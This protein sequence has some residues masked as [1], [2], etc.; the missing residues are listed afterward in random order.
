MTAGWGPLGFAALKE[1]RGLGYPAP[2][3]VGLCAVE[4]GK[5]LSMVRVLRIPFTTTKG[6]ETVSA[7]Q[8]VV[9]RRDRSRHGLARRLLGE[10]H[11]REKGAGSRFAILW[12][13]QS[14]MAH[15]LYN[16]MGY[17]DLYT[18]PLAM[19]RA[20]HRP[21]R[22]SGYELRKIKRADSGI[23]EGLHADATRGR[24][25][26]TPRA[27]HILDWVFRL[28]FAKREWLRLILRRGEPVGYLEL[29]KNLGWVLSEELVL[30]DPASADDVLSLL[31]SEIGDGWLALRG[32]FARDFHGALMRRGYSFTDQSYYGLLGLSLAGGGPR[33]LKALGTADPRFTCQLLDYF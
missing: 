19:R 5:V 31:E 3:Y 28:G 15:N 2:D 17:L 30:R 18:P 23:V 10:V 1:I 12:T 21:A 29:Q 14:N 22:P 20:G 16:S 26:F 33:S 4:S 25:G 13:N 27:T 9:T 11:R 24:L 7:I 8:G 6:R 32:T